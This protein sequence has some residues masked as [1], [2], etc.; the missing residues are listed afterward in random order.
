MTS[1]TDWRFRFM[2]PVKMGKIDRKLVAIL[3]QNCRMQVSDMAKALSVSKAT[4]LYH[5][6]KLKQEGVIS[7]YTTHLRLFKPHFHYA[8]FVFQT[9]FPLTQEDYSAIARHPQV[10]SLI[11]L[12]NAYHAFGLMVYSSPNE[13][14]NF[15][16]TMKKEHPFLHYEMYEVIDFIPSQVNYALENVPTIQHSKRD[17]PFQR[18]PADKNQEDASMSKKDFELLKIL[19]HDARMP[20]SQIGHLLGT[21]PTTVKKRISNLVENGTILKFSATI[22]PYAFSPMIYGCLWVSLVSHSEQRRFREFVQA[23]KV[24]N[25]T[26]L[27]V[28][29]WNL[30]TFLHF[31]SSIALH[32]F[33]QEL[34]HH[35][36]EIQDTRFMLIQEQVKLDWLPPFILETIYSPHRVPLQD[37]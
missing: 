19:A 6:E 16:D 27:L 12:S 2:K 1:L 24:G 22:N 34:H 31:H 28:G 9:H 8:A 20:L 13:L 37:A 29:K 17:R 14:W 15:F 36:P 35:F 30:L 10:I 18:L 32:E 11:T 26:L 33:Q 7:E 21:S 23:K 25:G 4:I 3:Q 5:L